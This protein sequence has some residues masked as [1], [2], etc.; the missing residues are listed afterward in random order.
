P[1]SD[2]RTPSSGIRRLFH[3]QRGAVRARDLDA[4]AGGAIRAGDAPDGVADAHRAGAVHDRLVEGED[5]ADEALRPAIEERLIAGLVV[6]PAR[7]HDLPTPDQ[8]DDRPAR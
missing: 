2:I 7:S 8:R 4:A 6:V 5:A 1:T 3:V